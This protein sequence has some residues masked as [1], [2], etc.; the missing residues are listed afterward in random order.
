MNKWKLKGQITRPFIVQLSAG[1]HVQASECEEAASQPGKSGC[2]LTHHVHQWTLKWT[3]RTGV[4]PLSIGSSVIY[5][6]PVWR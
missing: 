4:Q 1:I 5:L 2:K 3:L 6:C